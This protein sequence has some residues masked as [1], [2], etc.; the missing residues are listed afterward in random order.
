[1]RTGPPS[2]RLPP[3]SAADMCGRQGMALGQVDHS[4]SIAIDW[5]DTVYMQ[6]GNA[7]ILTLAG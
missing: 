2:W 6:D 1:M 3:G 7:R 4:T 5:H